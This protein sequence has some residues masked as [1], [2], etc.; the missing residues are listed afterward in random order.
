FDFFTF[1]LSQHKKWFSNRAYLAISGDPS[2]PL[3]GSMTVE[4]AQ[5]RGSSHALRRQ[6][7]T[8]CQI[9]TAF[10]FAVTSPTQ[11]NVGA[12]GQRYVS[13]ALRTSNLITVGS[14]CWRHATS[15]VTNAYT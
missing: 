5:K 12:R 10:P 4:L 6:Q 3:H 15:T 14:S 9:R 13:L 2:I 7:S 8:I 11:P 1:F